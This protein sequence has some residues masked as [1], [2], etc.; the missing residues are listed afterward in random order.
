M[1]LSG[2]AQDPRRTLTRRCPVAALAVLLAGCA[3]PA[4]QNLS[5]ALSPTA[6]PAV[7][8]PAPTPVKRTGAT[9]AP[10]AQQTA[11]TS[12]AT[13]TKA[14][15]KQQVLSTY[16]GDITCSQLVAPFD[17]SSNV[18]A[19]AELATSGAMD[20]VN[21]W[22]DAAVSGKS[23][24]AVVASNRHKIPMQV[25]AAAFRMNWLPMNIE[26]LYGR[27]MLKRAGEMVSRDST[28]GRKLYPAADAAMADILKSVAGQHTYQFEMHIAKSSSE[29][30]MALPGGFIVLDA[31][32][33]KDAKLQEK[34][35]FAI[36]HEIGHVLQR[37]QTRAVQARLID[38]MS[39]RGSIQDMVRSIK[40]ISSN[41]LPLIEL[42]MAGKLQFEQHFSSQ[43]LH[44]D[45]C[46]VRL[47]DKAL[48]NN[49]RLA[50]VLQGFVTN[51]VKDHP[52]E[53]KIETPAANRDLPSGLQPAAGRAN[54]LADDLQ[55]IMTRVTRP[56]DQHPA[57]KERIDNLQRT[58]TEVV[59]RINPGAAAASTGSTKT[60]ML[61][62]NKD[63]KSK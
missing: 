9:N 10:E 31:G 62:V 20:A 45:G 61:P 56:I 29:N 7:S 19:L 48:N 54:K 26:V 2:W 22:V 57:P 24:G 13:V 49:A 36:A 6:A 60:L 55:D 52:A 37:H 5:S 23:A 18:S 33:L 44:S 16:V 35:Y 59:K 28:V 63:K 30:A 8:T 14:D 46:A 32:L 47:L 50:T 15:G 34:A 41:A 1:T 43:E 21:S 17:L 53:S 40:S 42:A 25:R 3:T 51:L 11:G 4:M 58:L 38:I 39:M 12:A 27:E